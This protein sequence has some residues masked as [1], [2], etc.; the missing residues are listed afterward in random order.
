M[1]IDVLEKQ[2]ESIAGT[3]LFSIIE[4]IINA[5]KDYPLYGLD[6]TDLYF[7]E[8]KKIL[9][10]KYITPGIINNYIEINLNKGDEYNIWIMSSLGCLLEAFNLMELYKIPFEEVL[11]KIK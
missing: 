3:N 2:I 8:I 6:D 10:S 5:V 7:E 9:H 4:L 11:Y 1:K